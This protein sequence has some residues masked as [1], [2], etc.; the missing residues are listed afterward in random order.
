MIFQSKQEFLFPDRKIE[1]LTQK[2]NTFQYEC[3]VLEEENNEMR[4]RLGEDKKERNKLLRQ[5]SKA[6]TLSTHRQ[7]EKALLQVLQKEL[8]RLEEERIQLK[9][10]NRKLAQQL[11]QRAAKLGLEAEDLHAIQE[12]T[13]A[14]KNRRAGLSS[15]DGSDAVSTLKLHEGT[16]LLQKELE[17]KQ[18]EICDIKNDLNEQRNKYNELFDENDKLR[19]GMH[20]ILESVK[21]QDGTSDVKVTSPILENLITI[22][23]ARHLYGDYK[24]VMG[25][26]AQVER[27]EGVNSQLR[28]QLRSAR[29]TEDK[30]AS[31]IQR[32]RSKVQNLENELSNIKQGGNMGGGANNQAEQIIIQQQQM[33]IVQITPELGGANIDSIS[34]LSSQ[35]IYVL[36]ELDVKNKMLKELKTELD[37]VHTNS[38]S[39]KHQIGVLYEE[40]FE[41]KANWEKEKDEM[42]QKLNYAEEINDGNNAKVV[43]YENLL[44]SLEEGDDMVKKKIA[45]TSRKI[46]VLKSNE[47]VLTR[48]YRSLEKQDSFLRSENTK[49]RDELI[50]QENS[51]IKVIGELKRNDEIVNYK[52]KVLQNSLD[53]S[54]PLTVLENANKEFNDISAKYRDLLEKQQQVSSQSR[55][56]EEMELHLQSNKQENETLKKELLSSREKILSL[57]SLIN[58]I[59]A[60]KSENGIA[61]HNIEIERLTKQM[62]TLEIKELNER[63]KADHL[64]S[65][66]KL[67]QMQNKQL[68]ERN[69]ELEDKFEAVTKSNLELQ[70]VERDLRD[71]LVTSI[72]QKLFDEVNE[73]LQKDNKD[74]LNLKIENEKLKEVSEVAQN[75]V[76][77]LESR[78]SV[79]ANELESLRHQ[80][81]DLQSITDEKALIGRLHQ[82]M[83]S[84]Q[85]KDLLTQQ[86][87]L[88]LQKDISKLE[89]SLLKKENKLQT[90][91]QYIVN[92]R[93]Q[94]HSKLRSMRK[95]IQDLRRQYSGSIP[96]AKQE[97]FSKSLLEISFEKQKLSKLLFE[98][99]SKL[100]SL[101][102][103]KEEVDLKRTGVDEI[104]KT[105]KQS[106]GTKHILE[107]HSKLENLRMKELHSRRKADQIE[108]QMNH[109]KEES[110]EYKKRNEH[111]ED[112]LLRME[113]LMEQKQMEW[114][115][116]EMEKEK[117]D[118][119]F[120]TFQKDEKRSFDSRKSLDIDAPLSDQLDSSIKIN[121]D[122]SQEINKLK[123]K[124]RELETSNEELEKKTK[125]LESQKLAKEKMI[126]D[127]RLELPAS[128]DRAMAVTSVIGQPGVQSACLPDQQNAQAAAIA[129]STIE[130]LRE[131]L[132]LK[133]E[134]IE[135]YEKM[136]KQSQIEYNDVLKT[137][138][139][140]MNELQEKLKNVQNNLNELRSS[141]ATYELPTSD[142]V[143]QYVKRAMNLEFELKD[144]EANLKEANLSVMTLTSDNKRLQAQLDNKTEENLRLKEDLANI[145]HAK[146]K[147]MEYDIEQ[148]AV[149]IQ[150]LQEEN[151][152]LKQRDTISRQDTINS[153]SKKDNSNHKQKDD[154]SALISTIDKQK[155]DIID[156]DKKLRAMSK[157]IAD[158]KNEMMS[159]AEQSDNTSDLKG[160]GYIQNLV[161]RET[162]ALKTKIDEQLQLIEKLKRQI[163]TAKETEK[164]ALLEVAK[165]KD[166]NEKKSSLIVKLREEKA[167]L[168]RVAAR[169]HSSEEE[170]EEKEELKLEI[171]TLKEKLKFINKAEKP[172]EETSKE[173]KV[174]K[175]AE[176]VARW[177]ERKKWQ[178]KMEEMRKKLKEADEEVSK[179][180]KQND[181]LRETVTRLDREKMQLDMKWKNHLKIGSTRSGTV[182]AKVQSLLNENAQLR[183]R[184]EEL[185]HKT[186]LGQEPGAEVLKLRVK[187]L[188]DRVQQQENKI[189]LLEVFKKG[190]TDAIM[191]DIHELKKS[192][193]SLRVSNRKLEDA[194]MNLKVK[195]ETITHNLFN[196]EDESNELS[197]VII[198]IS[199]VALD[200]ELLHRLGNC[201]RQISGI[202]TFY[203]FHINQIFV[204]KHLVIVYKNDNIHKRKATKKYI[205]TNKHK[206]L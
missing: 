5:E 115:R 156:K 102:T 189:S 187:F 119:P 66:N 34:K 75:Q 33:P 30:A 204:V 157:V 202:R 178:K 101:E 188:Q 77:D 125:E 108:K 31:Q 22:L 8:E 107:W 85:N 168:T 150:D 45:E 25:V 2:V 194:N 88:S 20:E 190:G 127:L 76:N 111:L 17:V 133:E 87:V 12:Y 185:E 94:Y 18:K 57:E 120:Y 200:S 146:L 132:S 166:A 203:F 58:T 112:E 32:L 153:E 29:I 186:V 28:E 206:H 79:Y 80:V 135:S 142:T 97:K 181:G 91:E 39:C 161:D 16:I 131:R 106:K 52:L 74:L 139:N 49:L 40:Y 83:L 149:Q 113:S 6:S 192:D 143:D 199:P 196:L 184:I 109:V 169:S 86:K 98:A 50:M 23:D 93:T 155:A 100:K 160:P 26:K 41:A 151:R 95:V 147:D 121:K 162:R 46:A 61:N 193:K 68:D 70:K 55:T 4:E 148:M 42:N 158:L 14:L 62:A 60:N 173:D 134:T 48:K 137:K 78:K 43:E 59:G 10:E 64:D 145:D 69:K 163:K 65:Q 171:L 116:F 7:S 90:C 114:E 195:M 35:L 105:L 51:S 53:E 141:Q 89:A 124:I 71:E 197:K 180:A 56:I 198:A 183:V 122:L 24:P 82:Q 118:L 167:A 103:E 99:D 72:P 130:S 19:L 175:N 1:D 177:E 67:I 170:N 201:S 191:K 54:V 3:N 136:F 36:D 9:T 38:E 44:K 73:K 81:L 172:L 21:D 92:I 104:L 11:G 126:N 140:E 174:V 152:A 138:Q 63:Q 165:L 117:E 144:V 128:V 37:N 13:E 123:S 159:T 164:A 129:H 47:A 176:E 84:W 110:L 154:A 96:L 182:D 179:I 15:I 27:L 205:M